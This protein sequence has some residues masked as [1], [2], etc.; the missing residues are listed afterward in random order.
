MNTLD[1]I[2]VIEQDGTSQTIALDLCLVYH[3]QPLSFRLK[4]DYQN[5]LKDTKVLDVD[6]D[7][8]TIAKLTTSTLKR[9]DNGFP[10]ETVYTINE[11]FTSLLKRVN[12]AKTLQEK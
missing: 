8:V 6:L 4:E 1:T 9:V 7:K 12:V 10:I 5:L 3:L 11:S 2:E